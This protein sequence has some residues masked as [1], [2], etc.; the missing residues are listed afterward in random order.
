MSGFLVVYDLNT[1]GQNYTCIIEKLEKRYKAYHMQ[2]S[3]WV[4]SSITLT[5]VQIRDDL[6][7]CLDTNDKLF[8]AKLDET[9]WKT[10][11]EAADNWLKQ[12]ILAK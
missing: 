9:A 4:I 2:Q 11:S 8:V 5:T 6:A 1:P 7:S 12:A 3:A 10:I